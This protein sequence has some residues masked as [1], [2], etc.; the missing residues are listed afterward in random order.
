MDTM[1]TVGTLDTTHRAARIPS[2]SSSTCYWL[3]A[4]NPRGLGTASPE[5][6]GRGSRLDVGSVPVTMRAGGV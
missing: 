1:D 4:Q 3:K 2:P 5:K 6:R